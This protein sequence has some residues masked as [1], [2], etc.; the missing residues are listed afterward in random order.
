MNRLEK[1]LSN[2][3][4]KKIAVWYIVIAVI[5]GIACVG[6]L[7][8]LYRERLNFAWQYCHSSRLYYSV[9]CGA[10]FRNKSGTDEFGY[11]PCGGYCQFG[12]CD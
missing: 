9:Y 5:A 4:F 10:A 6:T 7:G 8:Y 3:N 1:I 11:V 2:W 12:R